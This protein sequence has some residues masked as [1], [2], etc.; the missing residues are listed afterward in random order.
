[1]NNL[2]EGSVDSMSLSI[3]LSTSSGKFPEDMLRFALAK[4]V[5]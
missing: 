5:L 3:A 2:S 4:Q 1:M